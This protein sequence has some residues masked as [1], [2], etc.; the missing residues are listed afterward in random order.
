MNLKRKSSLLEFRKYE[1][2]TSGGII[3]ISLQRVSNNKFFKYSIQSTVVIKL[4]CITLRMYKSRP[5]LAKLDK[6]DGGLCRK[7]NL[8]DFLG[9]YLTTSLLNYI[10]N[11]IH[12]RKMIEFGLT[13]SAPGIISTSK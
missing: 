6:F 8:C 4:K 2:G 13:K 11:N 9:L 10:L 12:Y 7:L 3:Q 1:H 5:E